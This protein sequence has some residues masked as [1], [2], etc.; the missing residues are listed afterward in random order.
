VKDVRPLIKL[1]KADYWR[2]PTKVKLNK[3]IDAEG[4]NPR[5]CTPHTD[6][7]ITNVP[8]ARFIR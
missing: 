2:S 7:K 3:D 4:V 8:E 1:F 5:G 6:K